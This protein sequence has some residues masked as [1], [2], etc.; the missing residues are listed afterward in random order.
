MFFIGIQ[1]STDNMHKKRSTY[2]RFSTC[3]YLACSSY[4]TVWVQNKKNHQYLLKISKKQTKLFV[5]LECLT[6]P[7]IAYLD[8]YVVSKLQFVFHTK[9]TYLFL[10]ML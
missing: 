5:N 8:N 9:Y 6:V 3:K 10:S 7:N 4:V 1:R 2:N